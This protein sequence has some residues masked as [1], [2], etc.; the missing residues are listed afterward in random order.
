MSLRVILGILMALLGALWAG[1]TLAA[2]YQETQ[3]EPPFGTMSFVIT[4]VL[5]GIVFL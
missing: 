2:A 4:L 5:G 1:R 3:T